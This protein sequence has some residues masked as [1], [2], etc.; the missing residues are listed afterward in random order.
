MSKKNLAQVFKDSEKSGQDEQA[1]EKSPI[2]ET[3]QVQLP[4]SRQEKKH[5]AGYFPIEVHDQLK[6]IGL[7]R[8]MSIQDMLAEA[9][10]AFFQLNDKPPLA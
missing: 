5:I 4:P 2:P 3:K 8:R 9:L 6:A 10:N 1:I 7:E